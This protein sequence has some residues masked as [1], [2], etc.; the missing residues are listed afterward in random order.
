MLCNLSFQGSFP[1]GWTPRR[2]QV[3]A[4]RWLLSLLRGTVAQREDACRA[5]EGVQEGPRGSPWPAGNHPVPLPGLL[6]PH[7]C[8]HQP[9]ENSTLREMLLLH[10]INKFMIP[11]I[12]WMIILYALH[13]MKMTNEFSL[14]SHPEEIW[15][16]YYPTGFFFLSKNTVEYILYIFE[17]FRSYI[18]ICYVIFSSAVALKHTCK[19]K[20]D[21]LPQCNRA[22][23]MW[24]FLQS[25]RI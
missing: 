21:V 15:K 13:T 10:Q 1:A 18:S 25:P 4:T 16:W 23:I 20:E 8:W 7:S 9:G 5:C 2:F 12:K 6:H 17:P 3:P 14:N 19:I 22:K 24:M 11:Q